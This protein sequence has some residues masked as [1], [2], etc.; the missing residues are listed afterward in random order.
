MCFLSLRSKLHWNCTEAAQK[1]FYSP[2]WT[3]LLKDVLLFLL[4]WSSF[5]IAHETVWNCSGIAGGIVQSTAPVIPSLLIALKMPWI[6]SETTF[7]ETLPKCPEAALKPPWN[8]PGSGW[9][10]SLR[11]SLGPLHRVDSLGLSTQGWRRRRGEGGERGRLTLTNEW[12]FASAIDV[13]DWLCETLHQ[14]ISVKSLACFVSRD[15]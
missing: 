13:S 8:C 11:L 4:S 1:L 9:V 14:L 7:M 6:C 5:R 10:P 3:N 12:P 15:Y 2:L